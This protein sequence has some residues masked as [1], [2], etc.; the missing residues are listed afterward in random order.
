[1]LK[2]N[3]FWLGNLIYFHLLK[4]FL[5]NSCVKWK[6]VEHEG[7]KLKENEADREKVSEILNSLK[8]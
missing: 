3:L 6:D 1:M 7:G 4:S 5:S 8:V 2:F